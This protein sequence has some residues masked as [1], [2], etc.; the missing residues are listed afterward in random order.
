[1]SVMPAFLLR[2]SLNAVIPFEMASIPVKAEVPLE[3]ACNKRNG[4]IIPTVVNIS[5]EGGLI[6]V[7][8][9]PP[10]KRTRPIPTVIAIV[11]RKK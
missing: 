8:R 6:T 3:N 9:F 4:V 2:G 11:H 10:I 5:V 7:P 1:M